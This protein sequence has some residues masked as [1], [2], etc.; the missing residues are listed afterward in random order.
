[1]KRSCNYSRNHI[2]KYVR[3]EMQT[4]NDFKD[5]LRETLEGPYSFHQICQQ[6]NRND[7]YQ[8]RF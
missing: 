4:P 8:Q 1:M 7:K 2:R 5:K 6:V 3:D